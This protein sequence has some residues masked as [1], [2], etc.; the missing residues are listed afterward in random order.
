M[1]LEAAKEAHA[2]FRR[3]MRAAGVKVLT[4]KDILSFGVAEHLGARCELEELASKALCYDIAE[5]HKA[6]EF[7]EKVNIFF[8]L[9][10]VFFRDTKLMSSL[11]TQLACYAFMCMSGQLNSMFSACQ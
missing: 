3:V 4:V 9:F 2:E 7:S 10:D 5:G 1:N 6:D 8:L 11:M